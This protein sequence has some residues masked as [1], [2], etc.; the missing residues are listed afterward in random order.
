[1]L[2][3]PTVL[4]FTSQ[5][6]YLHKLIRNRGEL[7]LGAKV[8]E[9]T[10]RGAVIATRDGEREVEAETVVWA[11]GA[12][13]VKA[14]G[15]AAEKTGIGIK[16]VGDAVQPRRLLEAVHEGYHAALEYMGIERSGDEREGAG[17]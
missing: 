16:R 15:E 11:V 17:L 13:P 10:D 1:E 12:R 7:I 4:P 6:Y 2:D 3:Y 9:V 8:L 14:V 5:G